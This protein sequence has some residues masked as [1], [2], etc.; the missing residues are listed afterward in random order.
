M[1]TANMVFGIVLIIAS[2]L[3]GIYSLFT[4]C[5]DNA[6]AQVLFG[7]P[8]C[9]SLIAI[10]VVALVVF[11]IGIVVLALGRGP[12]Q[13]PPQP[14]PPAALYYLSPQQLYPAAP[15]IQRPASPSNRTFCTECGQW[16]PAD[17][18]LCPKDGTTL[19]PLADNLMACPKCGA[20]VHSTDRFCTNCGFQAATPK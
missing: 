14:A 16:Y 15:P 9:S 7:V 10:G 2:L 17:Y 12:P 8:S 13:T 18:R 5:S 20:T 6:L 19:K 11:V 3:A 4:T 1:K